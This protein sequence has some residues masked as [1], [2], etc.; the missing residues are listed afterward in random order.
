[1]KL[2]SGKQRELEK[3]VGKGVYE[4]RGVLHTRNKSIFGKK[5]K[6]QCER[7]PNRILEEES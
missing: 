7:A 1:M 4:K 2:N 3:T 5:N 6:I